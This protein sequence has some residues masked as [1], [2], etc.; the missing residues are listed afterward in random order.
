MTG[1]AVTSQARQYRITMPHLGR[2]QQTETMAVH[3]RA[4][5]WLTRNVFTRAMG[6]AAW[7]Y[8]LISPLRTRLRRTR[9]AAR[10]VTSG[11]DASKAG[12]RWPRP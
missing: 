1:Q 12:G 6:C 3:Y 10:S 4:P 9:A 7:E 5:G 2:R 8:S 11:G